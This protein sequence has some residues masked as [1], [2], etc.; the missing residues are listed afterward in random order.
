MAGTAPIPV[1]DFVRTQ[2]RIPSFFEGPLRTPKSAENRHFLAPH[3]PSDSFSMGNSDQHVTTI[4]APSEGGRD[5]RKRSPATSKINN[6]SGDLVQPVAPRFDW[7]YNLGYDL[8]SASTHAGP[9]TPRC[10][11]RCCIVDALVKALAG[12]VR[13]PWVPQGRSWHKVASGS[14]IREAL[15]LILHVLFLDR[16]RRAPT[17]LG[18]T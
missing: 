11:S 5:W 1:G 4:G 16:C 8:A 7:G 14:R 12:A 6:L 15:P 10:V 17:G 3:T 13:S 9:D 18:A 2:R